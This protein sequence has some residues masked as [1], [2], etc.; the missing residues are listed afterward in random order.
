MRVPLIAYLATAVVF[1][2]LDFIWISL[3]AGPVYK[4]HLGGLMMDKPN[5]PVAAGFYLL[6][7]IGVIVFA[8]LPA[9]AAQDWVHALWAGALL[10]LVS[11]GAYD[12]TN[13]ATLIGWSS[14]VSIVDMAWG[15][16]A[17]AAAATAGYFITRAFG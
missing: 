1:F 14:F 2:T 5:L 7:V 8:V 17:T 12:L 3:A 10:G 16:C 6:Y 11:Y 4:A 13:Q 9:L 15:T